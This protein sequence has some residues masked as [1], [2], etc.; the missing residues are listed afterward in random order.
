MPRKDIKERAGYLHQHYIDNIEKYRK[1]ARRTRIRRRAVVIA[2]KQKPCMDC[3]KQY[4]HYVMDLDH[5]RGIKV[6]NV[7][8][9]LDTFSI[10]RIKDEIEKCDVVCSNCHRERTQKQAIEKFGDTNSMLTSADVV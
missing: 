8:G 10:Q 1:A 7:S 2:A 5:V 6:R 3:G 9:M 4:P